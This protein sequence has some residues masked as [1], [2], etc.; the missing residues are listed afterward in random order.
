[1]AGQSPVACWKPK[2]ANSA[3]VSKQHPRGS[4]LTSRFSLGTPWYASD[5]VPTRWVSLR[6]EKR[7][8]FS[9]TYHSGGGR[10]RCLEPV[11]QM[12]PTVLQGTA[13]QR[14][15]EGNDYLS[16]GYLRLGALHR[17]GS[18]VRPSSFLNVCSSNPDDVRLYR[19]L[20]L[21]DDGHRRTYLG[22]RCQAPFVRCA[23]TGTEPVASGWDSN[24]ERQ[25]I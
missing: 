9:D 12:S 1:M 8:F 17:C 13:V 20:S 3:P 24:S 16:I 23:K 15:N 25:N 22:G 5:T 18:I 2:R 4:R 21:G 10:K 14:P 11:P 7:S 6:D 19:A